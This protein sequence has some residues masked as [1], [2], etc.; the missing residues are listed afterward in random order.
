MIDVL[1]RALAMFPCMAGKAKL[2]EEGDIA[3]VESGLS[4]VAGN[5]I[6]PELV[7]GIVAAAGT[8]IERVAG[9]LEAALK[10]S[11]YEPETLHLS[12]YTERFKL[13]ESRSSIES[14]ICGIF[15]FKHESRYRGEGDDRP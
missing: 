14:G 5:Q 11:R 15:G 13:S 7:I 2:M 6:R 12:R 10:N 3:A 4:G 9:S 1:L 8:P